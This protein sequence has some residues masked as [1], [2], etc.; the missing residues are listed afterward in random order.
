MSAIQNTVR[1]Q[2]GAAVQRNK[3]LSIDGIL[4]RMF[5]KTFTGL[6]YPQIWEDPEQDMKALNIQHTDHVVTIASGGCNIMSY[7]TAQPASITAVDLSP[8]HIALNRLKYTAALHLPDYDAFYQFFGKANVKG[9]AALFDHYIAP[10]LDQ[11]SLDYWNGRKGL[12]ARR[13]DMFED[14]FY[15]YGA[16]GKF[17]G[18]AHFM[19]RLLGVDYKAFLACKTQAEQKAFFDAKMRPALNAKLIKFITSNR[20]SLFGLGIPP[21]QYEALAGAADGDIHAVLIERTRKLMCDFPLH[22]NYFAW[23]AFNRSYKQDGTGPLPLYLQKEH[24]E[25]VRNNVHKAEIHNRN[26]TDLLEE[27]PAETKNC[28]ILLDAQDWMT[29]QQLNAMWKQIDRTAQ[30][31]A[32]VIYRTAGTD[33]ILQG[34]VDTQ[35]LGNWHYDQQRSQALNLEDRSAIYGGFHIYTRK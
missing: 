22:E 29:D 24:Y 26:L 19:S 23:Q 2:L 6:V 5:A 9:N 4:E 18:I 15:R 1:T 20:A 10:Y 14:G 3:A 25:T 16:L 13:I 12:R 7:L 28:Y 11:Q 27:M 21:Q 34:R 30:S 32:R 17:I 8:A 35:I 33:D 31:G